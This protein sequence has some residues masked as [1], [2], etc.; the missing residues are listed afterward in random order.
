MPIEPSNDAIIHHCRG[1]TCAKTEAENGLECHL[2]VGAR[3]SP[4]DAENTLRMVGE[5]IGTYGLARLRST[6]FNDVAARRLATEVVIERHDPVHL[7]PRQIEG[8]GDH[9]DGFVG[10]VTERSLQSLEDR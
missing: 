1:R 7:G 5:F 8:L 2:T 9:A 6:Q 4:M 3:L 10:D